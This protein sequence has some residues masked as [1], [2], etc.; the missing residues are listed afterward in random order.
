MD[1]AKKVDAITD[2]II[3][4]R[5][6]VHQNPELGMQ[7]F[8]TTAKI[9]E[10]LASV[11]NIEARDLKPG[12]LAV[13]KG[14]KPGKTVVLRGDIDALPIAEESGLPFASKNEGVCHACGH[15]MHAAMVLGAAKVLGPM[16]DE[17]AGTIRF[18]FQPAEETL[19]GAVHCIKHGVMDGADAVFGLHCSPLD[20]VGTVITRPGSMMA[21]ADNI[22]ITVTGRPGHAAYPH[23]SIDSVV[24]ASHVV[25]A[26]QTI[27]AR[28]TDPVDSM[29]VT[30]GTIN[31]GT[32]R[33][34]IAPSV[35]MTGTVR[36]LAAAVRDKAPGQIERI[37]TMTA[38]ALGGK[39]EV[40][41]VKG[42]PPVVNDPA[43]TEV[44]IGAIKAELGEKGFRFMERP[45]MGGEDFAFYQELVPGTIFRIGTTSDDPQTHVALHNSKVRFDEGALAVGMK[46]MCRTA[47]DFLGVK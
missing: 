47:L 36:T 12:V 25:T 29:V 30:L 43:M 10:E 7:E 14:K 23:R 15:D 19:G 41:Y 2:S 6:Y 44:V 3:A 38:E 34:I 27:V 46:V 33:N 21:S 42:T 28:E 24:V 37:V 22:D 45:I 11:P 9:M 1:I 39:G 20:P 17:I 5:R 18:L 40:K 4:F 35:A 16:A 8:G 13:L 32:V 26:L 31:G